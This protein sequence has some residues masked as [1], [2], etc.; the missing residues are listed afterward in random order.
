MRSL[1]PHRDV[2]AY[3]LGV[4]DRADA[5][6]FED[7]LVD[8]PR[9]RLSLDELALP[10]GLLRTHGGALPLGA[11]P[12]PG[13]RL[14][15][16]LL[17]EAGRVRRV[18]RRCWL[19]SFAAGVALAVAVPTAVVLR[20]EGPAPL[21]IAATDAHGRMS[22]VLTAWERPWGTEVDLRVRDG[23]AGRRVCELVAVGRDGA[24][25]TVTTWHGPGRALAVSGG[26]AHRLARVD[27][28]EVR[29]RGG[30]GAGVGVGVLTVLT[31]RPR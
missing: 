3:A 12:A 11:P 4:L 30:V 5:F 31:L 2:G 1:E 13:P 20:P 10:A 15:D 22:A 9:C 25:E 29:V 7:H 8:C 6:R 17:G 23:A 14:L 21:R 19:W 26:T 18:R 16:R 27:R 28:F 24:E